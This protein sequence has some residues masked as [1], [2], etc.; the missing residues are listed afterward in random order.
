MEPLSPNQNASET[1]SSHVAITQDPHLSPVILFNN[2]WEAEG[3]GC[4]HYF[5]DE[6]TEDQK[7]KQPERDSY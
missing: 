2:S 1:F 3:A 5:K 4:C 7:S 6:K